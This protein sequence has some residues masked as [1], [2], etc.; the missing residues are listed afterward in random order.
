MK[1]R[2]LS[3]VIIAS[4]AAAFVS[5]FFSISF[6]LGVLIGSGIALAH[7]FLMAF[8][9]VRS[10]NSNKVMKG[11][12]V[13]LTFLKLAIVAAGLLLAARISKPAILGLFLGIATSLAGAAIAGITGD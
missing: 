8:V 2:L 3:G 12:G 5:F 1:K 13:L 10:V 4:F 7:F 9:L 6:A 11:G